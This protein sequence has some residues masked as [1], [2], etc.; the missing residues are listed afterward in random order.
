M[1]VPFACVIVSISYLRKCRENS[2]LKAELAASKQE[3]RNKLSISFQEHMSLDDVV[4][5]LKKELYDSRTVLNGIKKIL[6]TGKPVDCDDLKNT[7]E[8]QMLTIFKEPL[9]SSQ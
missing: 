6:I 9:S 4:I 1:L 5:K 7:I 3:Y 2:R 8:S